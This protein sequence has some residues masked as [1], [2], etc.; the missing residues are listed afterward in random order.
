MAATADSD[1]AGS[2]IM[3]EKY[4]GATILE[5]RDRLTLISLNGNEFWVR[6][7]VL[8]PE[9]KPES[10]PE[11]KPKPKQSKGSKRD[12]RSRKGLNNVSEPRAIDL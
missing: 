7:E 11:P 2:W 4:S 8:L 3:S 1:E 10:K 9:P 6:N 5:R 12:W